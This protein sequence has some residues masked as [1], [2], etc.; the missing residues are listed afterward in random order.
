MGSPED[1]AYWND[2]YGY[3]ER[4]CNECGDPLSDFENEYCSWCDE[5]EEEEE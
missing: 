5:D 1:D 2:K 4:K 3:E